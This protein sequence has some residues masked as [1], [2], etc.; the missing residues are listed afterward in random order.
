M[1]FWNGFKSGMFFGIV[2]NFVGN[3]G[4]FGNFGCG[5]GCGANFFSPWAFGPFN[6]FNIGYSGLFGLNA[7]LGIYPMG[8]NQ[9]SYLPI[10]NTSIFGQDTS[11]YRQ[12]IHYGDYLHNNSQVHVGSSYDVTSFSYN[13]SVSGSISSVPISSTP[14][15]GGDSI[16]EV[17]SGSI[18]ISAQELKNKWIKFKGANVL[19]H[20]PDEFY[21]KVIDI[22]AEI[23]CDPNDLMAVMNLETAGT[24]TSKIMNKSTK[25]TGLIQFMPATAR[26]MKTTIYNLASMSE[27]EQ[28]DWVK[29]YFLDRKNERKI[30]GWMDATT[31]YALVFWP[32][33][34]NKSDSY[35]ISTRGKKTYRYN[36]GLDNNYDGYI[37]RADLG[38]AVAARRA[39]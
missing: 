39:V 28:L 24:F 36:K 16:Q 9:N 5:Y 23:Q 18:T 32:S 37:T 13:S 12:R 14:V 26:S 35:V 6:Q 22:S 19:A 38:R 25:A 4:M 10:K 30:S 2:N 17:S 21:Q 3:I 1:S 7:N 33:A 20:L 11:S 31:L 29:K 15:T 27:V 34:A 8:S